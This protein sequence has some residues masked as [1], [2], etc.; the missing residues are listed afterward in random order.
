MSCRQ[1]RKLCRNGVLG[2]W[3]DCCREVG[4]RGLSGIAPLDVSTRTNT[5]THAALLSRLTH[6]RN[7]TTAF[8]IGN[9]NAAI[10]GGHLR[11]LRVPHDGAQ[12]ESPRLYIKGELDTKP[13]AV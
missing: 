7:L 1:F 6:Y 5:F 3:P 8:S 10:D 13:R 11:A 12:Q 2:S 9:V 4:L